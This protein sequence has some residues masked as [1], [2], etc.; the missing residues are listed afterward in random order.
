MCSSSYQIPY[1]LGIPATSYLIYQ[2]VVNIST[3]G[4]VS[5][6]GT[7]HY[8][9]LPQDLFIYNLLYNI[10]TLVQLYIIYPFVDFFLSAFSSLPLSLS[11]L[12]TH[13]TVLRT[14]SI[15]LQAPKWATHIINYTMEVVYC[16]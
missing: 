11:V 12:H 1:V 10:S 7:Q 4:F 13:H 8:I 6:T 16:I 3:P 15:T 9:D 5:H 14:Y 2:S